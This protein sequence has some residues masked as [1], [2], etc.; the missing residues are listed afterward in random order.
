MPYRNVSLRSIINHF[1]NMCYDIKTSLETQLKRA[2]RFGQLDAILEIEEKLRPFS[3]SNLHH[4]SG[5]AHPKLY[6]YTNES[7]KIPVI[8]LWGLVPNWVKTEVQFLK[9]WNATLNAR[10]ETIFEKPSFKHSAKHQRCLIYVDG[11]YE[12]H[13]YKGKTYPFYIKNKSDL[14]LCFAGLWSDWLNPATGELINTFSIVTRKGNPFMAKIHNNPKLKEPRMPLML[15]N[16]MEAEW[17]NIAPLS[18][19]KLATQASEIE[20]S[21]HTV[22]RLRGNAYLGNVAEVSERHKYEELVF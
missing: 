5:Y 9:F 20:L 17:L 19:N 12:H 13:H 10:V 1:C 8:S 3:E 11:F 6:I 18:L 22:G 15:N 4:V 7:P 2:I 14:P 21:A 16:E